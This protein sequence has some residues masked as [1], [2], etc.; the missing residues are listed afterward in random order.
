MAAG[1]DVIAPSTANHIPSIWLS[2]AKSARTDLNRDVCTTQLV[3]AW[4]AVYIVR[5]AEL[6][7]ASHDVVPSPG[8]RF[9]LNPLFQTQH[10]R[11]RR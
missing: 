6:R 10:L 8:G 4:P 3:I 5:I 1:D 11:R 7:P 9:C 2:A